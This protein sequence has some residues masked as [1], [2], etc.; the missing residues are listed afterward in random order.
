[1][2]SIIVSEAIQNTVNH[3][4]ASGYALAM[5]LFWIASLRL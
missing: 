3:W 4:I 5:T 1:M 2:K